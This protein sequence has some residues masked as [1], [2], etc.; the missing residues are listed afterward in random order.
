MSS[1]VRLDP[2]E[3]PTGPH[4][5]VSPL[6][7]ATGSHQSGPQ[8][9]FRAHTQA[10]E[11]LAELLFRTPERW[12]WE[13][14][15]PTRPVPYPHRDQYPQWVEPGGPNLMHLQDKMRLAKAKMPKRLI[16]A[17]ALAFV[18]LLFMGASVGF[19]LF[20]LVIGAGIGGFAIYEAN[21]PQGEIDRATRAAS[22][23][24]AAAWSQFQDVKRVWD[25]RIAEH[26]GTEQRRYRNA[27]LLFPVAPTGHAS[28]V[29]VVGGTGVGWAS[30][31][32]TMGSSVLRA[33]GPVMVL[34]LTGQS[35]AGPLES[36]AQAINAPT[37]A[38][39]VPAALETEWLLGDL[40]PRELADV[41]AE[42]ME[43]KRAGRD[44]VDLGAMDAE[45]IYAVAK[46][47]DRPMTFNRLA[48]G[49]Q[50]LRATYE[51][52]DESPLSAVEVTRLTER[53]D[54]LD[55]GERMRDE[56][57][58]IE[59]QLSILGESER[60]ARLIEGS[61]TVLWPTTGLAV[62]R[63]DEPNPRRKEFIDQVLFQAVAHHLVSTRVDAADPM[64]VVAGADHLGR[65]SLELMAHNA[66]KARVRL[67]FLFEHLREAAEDL[68]GGGD[69]VAVLMR[70]GN[71]REAATAAEY[72]GRGYS[73]QVSQLSRQVGTSTTVSTN[74]STTTTEGQSITDTKGGSSSR[75]W[76]H[77]GGGGSSGDNWSRGVT[78]SWSTS[79][80]QGESFAEGRS[81]NDG[82][83]LAR[84]YEFTVEPTHIQ[85]LEPTAFLIVDGDANGR[86]VRMAD[87]FPGSVYVPKL[88]ST[89]R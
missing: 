55:K 29:D 23:Q 34:D 39:T 25:G 27:P 48:A 64:L 44:S 20:L 70:L 57:R 85:N 9:G 28:R 49:V 5:A 10:T 65:T 32:T 81:Q 82:V 52:D 30:L 3:P 18:G 77:G 24:R 68:L 67:V 11:E 78:D 87:C 75:S 7:R 50:V 86:R 1:D 89:P 43:A 26:D 19:G 47:L 61:A 14:V 66:Y 88:S 62:I 56:L 54:L 15:E 17:G 37:Q 2:P 73:F 83:V 33:G 80:T 63:N 53:V 45:I 58:F 38:A 13:Y 31:I 72:V 59:S 76:G 35:V 69:S 16:W 42:A 71:P 36:L 74:Q 40:S 4:R 22:A 51:H 84:S 8:S 6:Q 60:Q 46:R 21:N 12:G 41:L 79:R